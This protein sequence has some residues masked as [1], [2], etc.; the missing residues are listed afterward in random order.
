MQISCLKDKPN[1]LAGPKGDT[2]EVVGRDLVLYVFMHRRRQS[3][4]VMYSA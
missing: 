3:H 4:G 1:I 2:P